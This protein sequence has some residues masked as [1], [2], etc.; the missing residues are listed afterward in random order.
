MKNKSTVAVLLAAYNGRQW[1]E[2]Q[3]ASILNQNNVYLKIFISIDPSTDTTREFLEQSYI[4]HDQIVILPDIGKFGGAAKNFF[5]LMRDVDCSIFDYV[6]FADQ[7]DIWFPDKL[8]RA[9][10]KLDET[11]SDG[12]SS[13]VLAFWEDGKNELVQKSQMQCKYDY[14]FE[15]AGPGCTYVMRKNLAQKIKQK[16]IGRW[17]EVNQLWLHDWFCYAYARSNG[18]TWFIDEK[19]SMCY[20]Q[21]NSN[22]VGVNKG[23][24][25]F[26]HRFTIIIK[27]DAISQ[28]LSVAVLI[29][30]ENDSFVKK[31]KNFTRL[32]FLKL[33]LSAPECRR[34]KL[35]KFFFFFACILMAMIENRN[36]RINGNTT[37][38]CKSGAIS[39]KIVRKVSQPSMKISIVT[40]VFNNA[41]TIK[42]AINSVLNQTYQ[43]IEYIIIDGK[44]TDGTIEI[45]QSYG[46]KISKF[47][48]EPDKGIY[49][50]MNKGLKLATGDVVGILNSDDFYIL[51]DVIEK[52]VKVF[53]EQQVESMFAD[54][55]YVKAEDIDKVVRYYDSSY[56]SLDKFAY[57]WMPAHPTF[58]IKR[59]VYERYGYFKIDYKIAADY[60]LLVRFLAK[61]G[62]SYYY[63]REPII[64][65]RIGGVSTRNLKSN[66]ILNQEIL[67][68]CF[69]NGIYSNWFMVL[70]KYP[71][72]LLGYF[73]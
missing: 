46:S 55:V 61:N 8:C 67:K 10:Q 60:E 40:V 15:A 26:L 17:E 42:D 12:Y 24:E 50:A 45:I 32:G 62:V 34:K 14:L 4:Q 69:E 43:D 35:E 19:P 54:L 65:M 6:A 33:A 7:D 71:R 57:G 72:K 3:I 29:G 28:S 63:L 41:N 31:W 38:K 64:K 48:S 22:Q 52:V 49:D 73:K 39:K 30:M 37:F 16:I 44:S 47:V 21:H 53:E 1:I 11:K 66:F 56:F 59:E 13:N 9:I 23:L 68:A 58:F 51:N 20:R 27:G 36:I 2:E 25:A 18:F 5:R 70:S